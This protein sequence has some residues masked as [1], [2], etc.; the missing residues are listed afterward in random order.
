MAEPVLVAGAARAGVTSVADGLRTRMP[1]QRFVEAAELLPHQVPAAVVWVVSATAPMTS[2]ESLRAAAEAAHTDAIVAVVNKIDDHRGW[3]RVLAVNEIRVPGASWVAVS[4]APRLGTPRLD[5]L[6]AA[7]TAQLADP[8]LA[9]RNA[10]RSRDVR[11]AA[12]ARRR[13]QLHQLRIELTST[14]RQHCITARADLL[15]GTSTMRSSTEV[16][17]RVRG[18]CADVRAEVEA[19]LRA[20]VAAIT[21]APV[22]PSAPPWR[23]PTLPPPA[24]RRLETQLMVVLGAGFGVGAALAVARLTASL[25]TGGWAATAGG[26]AGVALTAWVVRA[27]GLLHDR[28]RWERWA[29]DVVAALRVELEDAV[30]GRLAAVESSPD[31]LSEAERDGFRG[32][33]AVAGSVSPNRTSSESFL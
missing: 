5:A 20:R 1:D 24:G 14:V 11:R 27:R 18:R 25:I 9:R 33:R 7:L 21:P 2:T 19:T 28:A 32:Y 17:D 22:V 31:T 26:V 8:T 30:A 13:H 16:E 12:H 29:G 10:A 15:A 3:R 4:A 23:P 6:V